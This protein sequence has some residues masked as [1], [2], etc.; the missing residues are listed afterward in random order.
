MHTS[1]THETYSQDFCQ[2]EVGG[3]PALEAPGKL[4]FACLVECCQLDAESG[5]LTEIWLEV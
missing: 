5:A 4:E 2:S 3:P 1:G